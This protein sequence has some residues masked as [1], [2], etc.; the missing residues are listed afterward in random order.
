M[1]EVCSYIR[2]QAIIWTNADPIHW[3]IYAALGGDQLS[4]PV[5][6][7][8]IEQTSFFTFMMSCW[9]P[10]SFSQQY[11]SPGNIIDKQKNITAHNDV[12]YIPVDQKISS[13]TA[14]MSTLKTDCVN[15]KQYL[16][17]VCI[18]K[19]VSTA[20]MR[21][22]SGLTKTD[23]NEIIKYDQFRFESWFPNGIYIRKAIS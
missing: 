1:T 21:S 2:R 22:V 13:K 17:S 15:L 12:S 6:G 14:V 7:T 16:L 8:A 11:W 10:D 20:P 23:E 9:W 5:L 18:I 3:R 19:N 4:L